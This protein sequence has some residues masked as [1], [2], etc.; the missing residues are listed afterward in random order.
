VSAR[1]FR[2]SVIVAFLVSACSPVFAVQT[3][4]G[5]TEIEQAIRLS[6]AP[7]AERQRYHERYG[8]LLNHHTVV[9]LEVVTEFRR[10]ELRSEER[11]G[12][13]DGR[14]DATAADQ[15]LKPW[16]GRVSIIAHLRFNPQ[17]ALASVP[18]FEVFLTGPRG[19]KDI[20]PI[21][22]QQKPVYSGNTLVSADIDAVFDAASIPQ[23]RR[24][25]VVR[26]APG[27]L[28]AGAFDFGGVQ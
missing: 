25:I 8:V 17:N 22:M 24:T 10:V 19:T 9:G 16:R 3:G 15:F 21:E 14:F 11:I 7:A 20:L 28:A 6:R 5:R 13:G 1:A 4:I 26:L 18:K 23:A 12:F 27:Q 2:R